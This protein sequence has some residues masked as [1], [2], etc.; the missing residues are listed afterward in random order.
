[1]GHC[2]W[3]SKS[4]KASIIESSWP[5]KVDICNNLRQRR[6][7]PAGLSF[8]EGRVNNV[9][10]TILLAV[11]VLVTVPG[12]IKVTVAVL[13]QVKVPVL[14]PVT[15][16]VPTFLLCICKVNDVPNPL[17][18]WICWHWHLWIHLDQMVSVGCG[19]S[20]V[21]VTQ[22]NQLYISICNTNRTSAK[23]IITY[24]FILFLFLIL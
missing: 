16:P 24:R 2:D 10:V 17:L 22:I 11:V 5:S 23:N 7:K 15:V 9:P 20:F 19:L 14:L 4:A 21:W 3:C 12:L 1:M 6:Q 13:V 18:A 8:Y